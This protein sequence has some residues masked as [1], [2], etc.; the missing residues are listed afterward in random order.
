[1][2]CLAQFCLFTFK[3]VVFKLEQVQSGLLDMRKRK[4]MLRE[5]T[6]NMTEIGSVSHPMLYKKT[7][8][9]GLLFQYYSFPSWSSAPSTTL[10]VCLLQLLMSNCQWVY[11]GGSG[12]RYS[13][14]IKR[15]WKWPWTVSPNQMLG[16]VWNK[17]NKTRHFIGKLL[18]QITH[19]HK[20]PA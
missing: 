14:T 13:M 2:M 10:H 8:G 9:T 3:E 7:L 6:D 20:G 18:F 16:N 5:E 4:N 17:H 12:N 15:Y 19:S 1:M 11:V